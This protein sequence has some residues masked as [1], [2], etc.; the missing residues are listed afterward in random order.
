MDEPSHLSI[1]DLEQHLRGELDAEATARVQAHLASCDQ[2]RR[3]WQNCQDTEGLADQLRAAVAGGAVTLPLH[4]LSG[5][6]GADASG[7]DTGRFMDNLRATGLLDHAQLDEIAQWPAPVV[8]DDVALAHELV[9]K[10]LLTRFQAEAVLTGRTEGF[11]IGPYVVTGRIGAGGMGCVYKATHRRMKRSVALKVLP[12]SRRDDPEAQARFMRE[13]EA[14]AQLIH[15]NIVTAFDVGEEANITYLAMEYVEGADLNRLIKQEGKLDP[16]RACGIAYQAAL[17]L[18]H[19]YEHGIV[20]RDI[21]PANIL[22]T[23]K[24][25]VKVLDMGLARFEHGGPS[26][27]ALT[28]L[29]SEGLV[30]GT[31]DYISPEQAEGTRTADTRADIYSLG[32]TLYHMLTGSVPFPQGT[33]TQKLVQHVTHR[34][35]PVTELAPSVPPELG[36]V[37]AKMMAKNPDDRYQ[38]PAEV[39]QDLLPWVSPSTATRV[40]G[41]TPAGRPCAGPS[42]SQTT[43]PAPPGRT[44]TA[45]DAPGAD[46]DMGEPTLAT[47]DSATVA[48][49][50][51]AALQRLPKWAW[52][53]AGAGTIVVAAFLLWPSTSPPTS[54]A[55]EPR[56]TLANSIGMTLVYIEPGT[57]VM[58]APSGE[59]KWNEHEEPTHRVTIT[60]GFYIGAYEVTQQQYEKVMGTNHSHF[61]KG[62]D[63]PV[64]RVSW[65][66][67]VTF[68]KKLSAK[69]GKTYR[70]PTEAQWEYA[71][72]AGTATPFAFGDTI[73]T[74]QA[75]YKGTSTYGNAPQG[76]YRECTTPV[77]TFRPN[78]W[79]LYDMHGNV[80]EWCQD[81][82]A[83]D[84]YAKLPRTDPRGPSGGKFRVKRGGSWQHDPIRCRSADRTM[85]HPAE[86]CTYDT[87]FRV[88]LVPTHE[89]LPEAAE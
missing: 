19:A 81:W 21:K 8:G 34:P 83:K 64:E 40:S 62:G 11:L 74:D 52:G 55:V 54:G 37:L 58:G 17:G 49:G 42:V 68:C 88:V 57:F 20:H 27:Q 4:A 29:T 10:G 48:P 30:M 31:P 2:C 69:E 22:V 33:A 38:T 1:H 76:A 70:L 87:G 85:A 79:G 39:A 41:A 16:S 12:T 71:C 78:A 56:R 46:Q 36:Q 26:G 50:P 32:C 47:P 44:V 6:H 14:S 63:Y 66:H 13:V 43:P 59:E 25:V 9:S 3:S 35:P 67:A 28:T 61:S 86:H 7:P 60:Q 24:G 75:N 15:P 23:P 53:M 51:M 84:A 45:S 80:Y 73:S 5:P 72:R 65:E 18:E 82:Y 77:G 89:R